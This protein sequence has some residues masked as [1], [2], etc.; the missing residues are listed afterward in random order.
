MTLS[1]QKS[2]S[3]SNS[4]KTAY[5][6]Y[7]KFEKGSFKNNLKCINNYESFENIFLDVINKHNLLEIS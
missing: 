6:N 5:I 2:T 4:R 7:K 1:L 3:N